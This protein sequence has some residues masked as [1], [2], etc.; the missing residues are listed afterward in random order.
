M[1]AVGGMTAC[2]KPADEGLCRGLREPVAQ[3]RA[4]LEAH[5]ET[6]DAVGEAGADTVIGFEAGCRG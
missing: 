3:L 1:L 5:P 6:S 4:A 2:T